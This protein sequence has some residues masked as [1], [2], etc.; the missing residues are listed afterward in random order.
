MSTSGHVPRNVNFFG[1]T[2]DEAPE[3]CLERA[4]GNAPWVFLVFKGLGERS[5]EFVLRGEFFS[6]ARSSE[7]SAKRCCASVG[8]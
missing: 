5:V 6:F 2:L 4:R 7:A 8:V 1:D 3:G